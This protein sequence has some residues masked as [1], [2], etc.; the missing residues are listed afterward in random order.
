MRGCICVSSNLKSLGGEVQAAEELYCK[1]TPEGK[2]HKSH[3]FIIKSSGYVYCDS[4]GLYEK[5]QRP[6]PY[7][8]LEACS[9]PIPVQSLVHKQSGKAI[10]RRVSP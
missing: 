7:D 4:G 9:L 6:F 10:R 3:N 1:T 5:I 2:K 8:R